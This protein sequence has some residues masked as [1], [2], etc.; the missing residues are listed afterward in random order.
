MARVVCIHDLVF[1]AEA[2]GREKEFERFVAEEFGPRVG[3]AMGAEVRLLKGVR[4]ARIGGYTMLLEF[5]TVEAFTRFWPLGPGPGTE[6]AR[7]LHQEH[8]AIIAK[9]SSFVEQHVNTE[10]LETG[11]QAAALGEAL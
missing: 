6:E 11:K 2:V 9:Y 10:Y 5:P 3:G 8:A 7:T 4:G 1:C